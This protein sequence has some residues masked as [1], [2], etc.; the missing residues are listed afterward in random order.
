VLHRLRAEV[1]AALAEAAPFEGAGGPSGGGL[2]VSA[3]IAEWRQDGD[4]EALLL[5]AAD[6]ALYRAKAAGRNRVVLASH[7][8]STDPR[9]AA[10]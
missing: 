1:E 7:P 6:A 3:G 5:A 4:D 10:S 9:D 2:S 8:A